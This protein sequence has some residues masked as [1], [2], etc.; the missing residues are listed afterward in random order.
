MNVIEKIGL[1]ER[2]EVE[3][4]ALSR[5]GKSTSLVSADL[6]EEAVEGENR[7]HEMGMWDAVKSHPLACLWAFTMCFTI[8]SCPPF[9]LP[10]LAPPGLSVRI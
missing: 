2:S 3:M 10:N 1:R 8:V 6:M 9:D 7:E 5:N 4:R